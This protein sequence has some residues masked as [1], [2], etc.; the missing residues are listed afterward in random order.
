MFMLAGVAA[1]LFFVAGSTALAQTQT[2]QSV[3]V[4]LTYDSTAYQIEGTITWTY[5]RDTCA[6]PLYN[7]HAG[8]WD[9]I[10]PTCNGSTANRSIR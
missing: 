5:G 1:L 10:T 8:V 7:A 2:A 3:M 4:N 6:V 9:G